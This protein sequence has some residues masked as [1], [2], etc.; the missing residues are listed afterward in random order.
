[1]TFNEFQRELQKRGIKPQEAYM[2]TLV[3]ERLL[4]VSKQVEDN[5][6][7]VLSVV[8][9]LQGVVQLT[10]V[11]QRRLNNVARGFMSD[12][13]QIESVANDPEDDRH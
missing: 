8:E 13:I 11:M 6:Q 1:M 3:Y 12:G 4:Q 10:D 7:V 5:A 9:S 2:F